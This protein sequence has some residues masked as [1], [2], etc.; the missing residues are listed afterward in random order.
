MKSHQKQTDRLS[1]GAYSRSGSDF[2]G[3]ALFPNGA[4]DSATTTIGIGKRA[5][6]SGVDNGN[7]Q[8]V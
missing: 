6:P 4:R 1:R 7:I 2:K 8:L 5:K 3:L